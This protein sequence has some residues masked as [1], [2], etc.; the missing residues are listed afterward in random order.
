[1]LKEDKLSFFMPVSGCLRDLGFGW[2]HHQGW[3][4]HLVLGT[5]HEGVVHTFQ[6]ELNVRRCFAS[7]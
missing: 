7:S 4:A 1:L 5:H 2:I 6:A 3:R